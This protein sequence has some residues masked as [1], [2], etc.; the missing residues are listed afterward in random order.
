MVTEIITANEVANIM[1]ESKTRDDM[2]KAFCHHILTIIKPANGAGS[3]EKS[4]ILETAHAQS[5]LHKNMC[6][7]G[8]KRSDEFCCHKRHQECSLPHAD[9]RCLDWQWPLPRQGPPPTPS[10]ADLPD[11]IVGLLLCV[12]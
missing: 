1:V 7:L 2:L 11:K 9:T 6:H 10:E 8:W 4:G 5:G 12:W 3:I